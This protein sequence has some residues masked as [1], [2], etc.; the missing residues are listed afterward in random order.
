MMA[1]LSSNGDAHAYYLAGKKFAFQ[2]YLIARSYHAQFSFQTWRVAVWALRGSISALKAVEDAEKIDVGPFFNFLGSF[3]DVNLHPLLIGAKGIPDGLTHQF[4]K[5][6]LTVVKHTFDLLTDEQ[7]RQFARA[8]YKF[9]QTIALIFRSGCNEY[10]EPALQVL[11]ELICR[12]DD[13]CSL[14]VS[15][16]TAEFQLMAKLQLTIA[17]KPR[18]EAVAAIWIISNIVLNSPEDREVV[19]RSGILANVA[20]ACRSGAKAVK[21]EAIWCFGNLLIQMYEQSEVLKIRELVQNFEIETSLLESLR[22]DFR[23]P[24][25]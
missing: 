18:N 7:T 6:F 23:S 21:K 10:D 3:F 4:R 12:S 13:F 2:L 5:D 24:E 11:G 9:G 19:I 20:M 14:V 17:E 16:R 1:N 8:P 22:C 15:Q 25:S